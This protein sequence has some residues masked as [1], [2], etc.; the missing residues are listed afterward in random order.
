MSE[1]DICGKSVVDN[2]ARCGKPLCSEHIRYG[3]NLRTNAP[4][5]NCPDCK[6]KHSR[7]LKTTF[8]VLSVV[9]IIIAVIII[10]YFSSIFGFF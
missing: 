10:L 3:V 5:I 9:F 4:T 6:K 1:C 8:I 7:N 2:C